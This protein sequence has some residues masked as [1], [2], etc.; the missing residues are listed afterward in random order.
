MRSCNGCRRRFPVQELKRG[1]CR[2]CLREYERAR[3]SAHQRG[4]DQTHRRLRLLAIAAHPYCVDCHSTEDLCADHVVPLSRGGMNTLGN[5][6]VRCRSCNTSRRNVQ[7]RKQVLPKEDR[8]DVYRRELR[9]RRERT[10]SAGKTTEGHPGA[11]SPSKKRS[12]GDPN[13]AFGEIQSRQSGGTKYLGPRPRFSRNTL[14]GLEPS[15]D[16]SQVG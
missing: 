13:P 8:L 15:D 2:P 3:G 4:Y 11:P 6:Q 1:R 14:T 10:E 7:R 9:M 16:E 12:P 5:Y